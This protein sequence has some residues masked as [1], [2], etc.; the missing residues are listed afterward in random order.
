MMIIIIVVISIQLCLGQFSF[1]FYPVLIVFNRIL[2]NAV[3]MQ[4]IYLVK[5]FSV[6][7]IYISVKYQKVSE[8]IKIWIV[9]TT[10][11]VHPFPHL[12]FLTLKISFMV[13]V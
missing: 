10:L 8:Q 9:F 4:T 6:F 5:R 2:P 11:R 13:M 12:H 7:F 1:Q 3:K